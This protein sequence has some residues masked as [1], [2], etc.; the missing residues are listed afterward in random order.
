MFK[1]IR[2]DGDGIIFKND[3]KKAFRVPSY[4]EGSKENIL[5]EQKQVEI[6]KDEIR[7]ISSKRKLVDCIGQDSNRNVRRK[8]EN[9]I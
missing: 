3:N 4:S 7:L 5:L 8:K 9:F 2:Y 6:Q 1:K